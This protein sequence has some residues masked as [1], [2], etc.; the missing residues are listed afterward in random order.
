MVVP[1]GDPAEQYYRKNAFDIGEYGI[2]MLANSLELGCDCLGE[3]RYF[4]AHLCDSRGEPVTITNAIC[5]H[6]EDDGILWKHTDW[7]TEPDRGA[8]LAPAGRL[9]HRHG[10]QLR[11]RLL[12]VLLPG[13]HDPVEVKLTGIMTPRRWPRARRRAY[14]TVVAPAAQ[15]AASTSTSS[16]S[17]ST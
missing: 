12:L 8:P 11:V 9:V 1:Y 17:G 16:T 2:G 14:G 5:M 6:E 10:R 3:I 4:D 15:R 13:R 7:R